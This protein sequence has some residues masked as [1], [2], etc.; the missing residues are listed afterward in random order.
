MLETSTQAKAQQIY[1]PYLICVL[2]TYDISELHVD[3]P[4]HESIAYLAILMPSLEVLHVA[5]Y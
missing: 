1:L 5:I 2:P 3:T 4:V